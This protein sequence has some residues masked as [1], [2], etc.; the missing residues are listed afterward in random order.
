MKRVLYLSV[1]SCAIGVTANGQSPDNANLQFRCG[2]RGANGVLH[3]VLKVTYDSREPSIGLNN[4]SATSANYGLYRVENADTPR[5]HAVLL[6]LSV[7]GSGQGSNRVSLIMTDLSCTETGATAAMLAGGY[8]LEIAANAFDDHRSDKST[9]LKPVDLPFKVGAASVTVAGNTFE[10]HREVGVHSDVP[11]ATASFENLHAERETLQVTNTNDIRDDFKEMKAVYP[12]KKKEGDIPPE[13]KRPDFVIPLR[14]SDGKQYQVRFKTGLRDVLGNPVA[15]D[16]NFKLPEVPKSDDDAKITGKL[17][18]VAAVHQK[19]VLELSGKFAPLHR[20]YDRENRTVYFDPSL[21]VDVG[22]HST[23]AANSVIFSGLFRDVLTRCSASSDANCDPHPA[24]VKS[25]T[26]KTLATFSSWAAT[27]PHCLTQVRF[28]YGPRFET[29][30][31][32][33]RINTLGEVRFDFDFWR[34]LGGIADK[35]SMILG[36]LKNNAK[37]RAKADLLEGPNWGF[38]LLPYLEF[39]GGGHANQET[40]TNK[41]TK[42]S[43]EVPRHGIFRIYAGGVAKIEYKRASLK[44][45]SAMIEMATEEKIG[46]VTDTGV[47]LRQVRGIQPHSLASFDFGMDP[48]RHYVFSLSYENGR[49]APNFEYLNKFT[50]G[51]KLIY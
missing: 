46:V 45:D 35:R 25:G 44:I 36:D 33:Q 13:E 40:V 27:S 6:G 19:A 20:Y 12:A 7:V 48:A 32:F 39:D 9:P 31:N 50:S 17:S 49:S 8:I 29:D 1:L 15:A 4:E 41:K 34:L 21:S 3:P 18:N 42:T 47:V 16:G 26:S 37:Y 2:E 24:C 23:K 43:L 38:S 10:Q 5:M 28:A 51:I 14:I 11:L 30:R 22:L